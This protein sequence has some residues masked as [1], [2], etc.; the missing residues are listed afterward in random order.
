MEY[1]DKGL[2]L[3]VC[4]LEKELEVKIMVYPSWNIYVEVF[5]GLK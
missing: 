2:Y 5:V 1:L 4:E 3:V